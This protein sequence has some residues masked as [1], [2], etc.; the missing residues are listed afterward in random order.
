MKLFSYEAMMFS[1]VPQFLVLLCRAQALAKEH[2]VE[3]SRSLVENRRPLLGFQTRLEGDRTHPRKEWK[4]RH[5]L[6][7]ESLRPTYPILISGLLEIL[8]KG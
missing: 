8:Q 2:V 5:V 4:S 7:K 1:A 3:R 6:Y